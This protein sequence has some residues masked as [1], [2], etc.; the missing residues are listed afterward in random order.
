[1]KILY[2]DLIA[3]ISG[4]MTLSSLMHL[5]VPEA[6][7]TQAVEAVIPGQVSFHV[8]VV[9]VHSISANSTS[10]APLQGAMAQLRHHADIVQ[11][12]EESRLAPGVKRRALATFEVLA[13]GESTVHGVSP[14]AVHFHEVGA[15]DSIADIVGVSAALEHLGADIIVS[16]PVPLG[17]GFVNTE[18]GVMPVPVPATVA[19][20][21]GIPV[22]GTDVHGE[23]TTPTGAALVKAHVDRFGPLPAMAIEATGWGAG[24]RRFED[25]PNLLRT[26][27][28]EA[29][30][31]E[32]STVW[33]LEATLDDQTAEGLAF[34]MESLFE[35]GALDVWFA[36]VT[37]KKSR[38]G[39]VLT[40]LALPEHRL[41]L[42]EVLYKET[43]TLGIREE[44]V[45]RSSLSRR[46]ESRESSFGAVRVK[47]AGIGDEVVTRSLEFEDVR[48]L[49][50]RHGLSFREMTRRL[51]LELFPD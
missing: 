19:I 7:V 10:I 25:R 24:S 26:V 30:E 41:T 46:V 29:L 33:K 40:V 31:S 6:V 14:G 18:H 44:S 9:K 11:M 35:H 36:P 3:G 51:S 8:E 5:G 17:K 27:L 42:R 1:M 49:A 28:G 20:L 23:M 34:A 47:I 21:Q 48:E 16:S 38:P 22:I 39:V 4:D 32:G 45:V 15:W 13:K 50:K 12:I 37:M 43:T 2:F